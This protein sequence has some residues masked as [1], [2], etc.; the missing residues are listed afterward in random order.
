MVILY[1]NI[2]CSWTASNCVKKC[3][4]AHLIDKNIVLSTYT[5]DLL[6]K[7]CGVDP[8]PIGWMY[9]IESRTLGLCMNVILFCRY[10]G[11]VPTMKFDYG[12]TY[13]N[14]TAKY[15]QDFRS[16]ALEKSKTNYCKGGYFPTYY[17]HNPDMAIGHRTRQWD[18]WLQEPRYTV[19]PHDHDRREELTNFDRVGSW[20]IMEIECYI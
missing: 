16:S 13:G 3:V 15:F 12:E 2:S 19:H 7:G 17:T 5:Y 8:E 9:G 14:H 6:L 1:W 11:H 4:S 18:R 20:V 10:R